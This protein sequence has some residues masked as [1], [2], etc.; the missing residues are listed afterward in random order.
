MAS[1]S[2]CSQNIPLASLAHPTPSVSLSPSLQ[3]PIVAYTD[4]LDPPIPALVEHTMLHPP[5]HLSFDPI[6]P[7]NRALAD[8][9][10]VSRIPP[11]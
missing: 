1:R 6:P 2:P 9:S 4:E 8:V 11:R 10:P 3:I 5:N 7:A